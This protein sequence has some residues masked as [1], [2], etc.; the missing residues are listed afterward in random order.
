[1]ASNSQKDIPAGMHLSTIHDDD[2]D[3]IVIVIGL[4]LLLLLLS[5]SIGSKFML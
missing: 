3:D 2:H 4:L 5:F 1:M